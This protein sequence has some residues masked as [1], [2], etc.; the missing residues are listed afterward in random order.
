VCVFGETEVGFESL[1]SFA[2]LGSA[3]RIGGFGAVGSGSRESSDGLP[4]P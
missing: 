3:S 1:R 4:A 2:L